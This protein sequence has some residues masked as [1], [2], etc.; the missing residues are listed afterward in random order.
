MSQ[1]IF[2]TTDNKTV[3]TGWDRPLQYAHLTVFDADEEIVFSGL[4]ST[5][6]FRWRPTD[7][8]GE[9]K[10]LGIEIPADLQERLE[11]HMFRDA[12][13]EQYIYT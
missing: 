6:I 2:K 5:D 12:G 8:I 9:L 1:I 10:T 7:V 13:N 4:D 11:E 3:I